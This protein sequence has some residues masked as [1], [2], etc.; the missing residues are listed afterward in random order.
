MIFDI[1]EKKKNLDNR[2]A[3]ICGTDKITYS[4]LYHVSKKLGE[5]IANDQSEIVIIFMPNGIDYVVSYFGI[6]CAGKIVY[7]ISSK[8]KSDELISAIERT[9]TTTILC[10]D[11]TYM[12]AKE[13]KDMKNLNLINMNYFRKF[14]TSLNISNEV[15]GRRDKKEFS[16]LLN[17]S[18][19]TDIHKIVMLSE[20]GII[21]N[22]NDW[23]K[24]AL[25]PE[26]VGRI[27]VA[28]PACTSFG[29]IVITTAIILGWTI[30]FSPTFFNSATLL[31][32]IEDK[33]ITHLVCI[34][35]MLNIL[36]KDITNFPTGD[37]YNS[38]KFIGIG[39][40]KAVPETM[41]TMMRFFKYA[42]ISPGYGITEAT[43]IVTAI[44]PNI[45]KENETLFLE[46]IESAGVPFEN[47]HISIGEKL[48]ET[49]N[50][51]E[52]LVSGPTVMKGYYNNKA[53]TSA[54][55]KEGILHTGDIGYI[56][57]EGYLFI[58]GRSKN[59]IKS[60]GYTIFP[61]E[62]EAVLQSLECIKEAYVYGVMDDIL[63]EKIVADVILN[64]SGQICLDEIKKACLEH[65]ADYKV[66]ETIN[67]VNKI[68]K[69]K[70]G[71]I[72]RKVSR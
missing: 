20:E 56:D 44:A 18:G 51:G 3:V 21:T 45:S 47:V 60:G 23:I 39:G 8:S 34:G 17:T 67:I 66:P 38:L 59:I 10:S 48:D 33:Q 2:D 29:T 5:Y 53:A 13:F 31:K 68:Q 30:F 42:G 4:Q 65:L 16:V 1:L 27:L 58:V 50:V 43:C 71:K 24:A 14:E 15:V 57:N 26:D 19:S 12:R 36:A 11:E 37:K 35:S 46:K 52:I 41:K 22:C 64:R 54:T 6:L 69:T 9:Q 49:M 55:L 7:P 28:M 72:Y 25:N 61:E 40:N 63:D 70:T 32:T 62:V